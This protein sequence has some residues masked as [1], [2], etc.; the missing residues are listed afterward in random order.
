MSS[1]QLL[2]VQMSL[3]QM[4]LQLLSFD[5]MSKTHGALYQKETKAWTIATVLQFLMGHIRPLSADLRSFQINYR[6]KL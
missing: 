6:I 1:I 3:G 5:R 2:F 4:L